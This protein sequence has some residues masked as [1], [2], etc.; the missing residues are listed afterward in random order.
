MF[1]VSVMHL[2]SRMW[3]PR[4]SFFGRLGPSLEPIISQ[5]VEGKTLRKEGHVRELLSIL[6]DY[7][8]FSKPLILKILTMKSWK[9]T[10]LRNRP[11]DRFPLSPLSWH[12]WPITLCHGFPSRSFP[13]QSQ[14]CMNQLNLRTCLKTGVFFI[15]G[16]A[17][18]KNHSFDKL[19]A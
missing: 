16:G 12:V 10:V 19:G 3:A 11:Q 2:W 14:R 5:P 6:E 13:T 9:T 1:C 15:L 18:L 7:R 4:D 17:K 8:I